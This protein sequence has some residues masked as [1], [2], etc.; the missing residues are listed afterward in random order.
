M[1]SGQATQQTNPRPSSRSVDFTVHLDPDEATWDSTLVAHDGHLMQSWHWGEFKRHEGW[2]VTRILISG[3]EGTGQAQVL[4]WPR[5]PMT[6]AF[7]PRGPLIVGNREAVATR[8]LPLID[9]ACRRQRSLILAIEAGTPSP[10]NESPE[11][12]GFEETVTHYSP[13][14]TV[15]VP[16]LDDEPLLAQMNSSTRTKVRRASRN[17]IE[18]RQAPATE[19]EILKFHG[20][21]QQTGSRQEFEVK[22]PDHYLEAL[23]QFGDDSALLF[24]TY[25]GTVVAGLIAARFGDEAIYLFGASA[26]KQPVNGTTSLLQ[27]EAMR[28]AR[29][30]GARR[31][32]MW[33][34]DY[35]RWSHLE[36][37]L[38][39][40]TSRDCDED[41]GLC[42]FK[43]GFGGEVVVVP[44]RIERI[45]YPPFVRLLRWAMHLRQKPDA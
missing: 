21:I 34:I 27:Y 24:A 15:V 45:Y 31:Y 17:G 9:T 32:D 29:S 39:R 38:D 42:R 20:L 35:P 4:F 25:E 28:W 40:S 18:I 44:R 22:S 33:G 30:R 43:T 10:Y 36:R 8:L 11:R 13:S 7:I 16:L 14:R 19:A 26:H 2:R 6:T 1:L 3:A 23:R 12:F 5:G 41:N 37:P